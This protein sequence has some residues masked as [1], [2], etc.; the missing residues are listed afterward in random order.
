MI[1]LK[2]ITLVQTHG[3]NIFIHNLNTTI[4][5]I[6]LSGVTGLH[7]ISVQAQK[8]NSDSNQHG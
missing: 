3:Q 6:S 8:E 7:N 4:D 2:R 5:L 1:M